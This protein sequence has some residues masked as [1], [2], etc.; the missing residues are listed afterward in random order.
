MNSKQAN[1]L[2]II[3]GTGLTQMPG[4]S[5]ISEHHPESP[6]GALSAPVEEY[7]LGGERFFFLA[8]H[9]HP[10][11][12]A[13]HRVNYRANI[14]G[15]ARLGVSQVVAVN[16]VGAV[17]PGMPA[18]TIVLPDQIIDYTSDREHTFFDGMEEPLQHIDFSWPYSENLRQSLLGAASQM[19][20]T[21]V[22]RAVYGCTQGPRLE[23]VAEVQ[24]LA[25]DGCDLVGMTGMPEAGLARERQLDYACVALV[26]NPAAGIGHQEITMAEIE[27][28]I[29]QGMGQVRNLLQH[30]IQARGP[31]SV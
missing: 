18:T 2:A 20:L 7:E 19:G 15:L 6:Y 17:H 4:V 3:G 16:A 22:P 29:A 14:D 25:R 24:R 11:S 23:T 27:Q 9:G 1:G 31:S 26:V 28:A 12:I 21:V 30:W 8:R 10:H 13:P 5:K